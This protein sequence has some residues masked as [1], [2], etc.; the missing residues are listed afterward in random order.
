MT[1]SHMRR[2]RLRLKFKTVASG[3]NPMYSLVTPAREPTGRRWH[4]GCCACCCSCAGAQGVS[5]AGVGCGTGV[6]ARLR[7]RPPR[8]PRH[9]PRPLRQSP[10]RG[11]GRRARHPSR[12]SEAATGGAAR[13]AQRAGRRGGDRAVEWPGDQRQRS[14]SASMSAPAPRVCARLAARCA[15][16]TLLSLSLAANSALS[17]RGGLP[18]AGGGAEQRAAAG[19]ALGGRQ[20]RRRALSPPRQWRLRLP[21]RRLT[22]TS[23]HVRPFALSYLW[24]ERSQLR[25]GGVSGTSPPRSSQLPTLRAL[26][27]RQR[28]R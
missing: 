13:V 10:D 28:A 23:S 1:C 12:L 16:A 19:A 26:D 25:L 6:S 17:G 27:W 18:R 9:Q 22:N 21:G 5:L 4:Q 24:L 15:H 7:R 8:G 14:A 20:R 3:R 11:V 2:Q